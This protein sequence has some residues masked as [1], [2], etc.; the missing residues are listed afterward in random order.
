VSRLFDYLEH[1]NLYN[2][3]VLVVDRGAIVYEHS[4][5]HANFEWDIPN[6]VDTRFKIGSISK[7]FA[8]MLIVQ[9]VAEDLISLD[10]PVAK[11]LPEI[12]REWADRVTIHQMLCQTSGIPNYTLLEGYLE[13]IDMRR[14]TMDEFFELL[15]GNVLLDS[16]HFEPGTEFDYSNTNYFLAGLIIERITGEP[17]DSVLRRKILDPL[18]M[19][20]TGAFDDLKLVRRRA[21]GYE[22]APDD[23]Y[24]PTKFSSTSPK[25]VPSGG[26]YS[27]ARDMYKWHKGLQTNALLSPEMMS[28]Y[29]GPHYMFSETEGYGYGNYYETY[30][31]EALDTLAIFEHG[32]SSFGTST[33]FYRIPAADQCIVLLMNGGLGRETFLSSIA[34]AI[35]DILHGGQPDMPKCPLLGTVGYTLIAKGIGPMREHYRYLKTHRPDAYRFTPQDL[36]VLGHVVI[37]ILGDRAGAEGVFL[38]NVEEYPEEA[39]P[40]ADIGRHYLQDA[41]YEEAGA[42]LR[43]AL[44]ISDDDEIRNLLERAESQ[45]D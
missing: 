12:G 6:T 26:L 44:A 31:T 27:T 4:L 30:V 10:D 9:L 11:F 36:S 19:K 14:F 40:Y 2:G 1:N 32:G 34:Y 43:K 45:I 41:R 33:M 38:L 28:R 18:D 37:Q 17:Y 24:E 42:H 13:G 7:Q 25:S 22:K 35:I 21:Y 20:D 8:A 5:G 16:L 39:L 15:I 29:L 3:V 23:T